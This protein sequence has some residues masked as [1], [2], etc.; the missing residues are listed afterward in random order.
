MLSVRGTG[1]EYN[2]R[3]VTVVSS[4][5]DIW[6]CRWLWASLAHSQTL[7]VSGDAEV[8]VVP[9][10]V[11]I[12]LGVETRSKDL[13]SARRRNDEI[14]QSVLAVPKANG[15]AREDVQTDFLQV[16]M[17]HENDGLTIKYYL[18]RKSIT[19][20]LRDIS[21]F[22][23][24]I[25]QLVDAGATHLHGIEF[26]TSDL[27]KH[28]DEARALAVKAATEKAGDLAAAAGRKL[29]R[30]TNISASFGGSSWYGYG[31]MGGGRGMQMQ[32]VIQEYG[33]RSA[34]GGT[35][36]LGRI[37]VTASVG[38]NFEME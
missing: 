2:A 30:A 6:C 8:K 36:S 11:D 27:R 20:A 33:G 15:V 35:V 17:E 25:A 22:E 7:S 31:W 4:V 3:R 16:G 18:V 29:G 28:R 24:L 13:A 14:V 12:Y 37:S 34:D 10:R 5:I 26:R 1:E 21:K 19:V 23:S 38:M 9:D 32:N